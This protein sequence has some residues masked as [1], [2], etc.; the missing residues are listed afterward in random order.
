MTG[1]LDRLMALEDIRQ[2]KA[3]YCRC[4]D[5]KDWA[6]L[7]S[8]FAPDAIFHHRFGGSV[9]DPWTGQWKPP[10]PEP[11]ISHGR[12]AI[13]ARIRSVVENIHTL[14]QCHMPE[15]ALI[16]IFNARGVWA[17]SDELRDRDGQLILRG[18]GHYH[19]SYVSS[20]SGW[21]IAT[22]ELRRL[23]IVRGDGHPD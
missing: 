19:E 3:R 4:V 18:A 13:V 17:M 16:D 15:I 11:R 5:T 7:A 20:P 12:A 1:A 23:S 14:H 21:V 10:L 8:V 22:A 2:L 6:G 9:R